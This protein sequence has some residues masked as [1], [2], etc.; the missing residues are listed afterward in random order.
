MQIH[1]AVLKLRQHAEA[2]N[3]PLISL[4]SCYFFE[5]YSTVIE[6]ELK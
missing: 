1:L 2:Q 3:L 4:N 6:R 5:G